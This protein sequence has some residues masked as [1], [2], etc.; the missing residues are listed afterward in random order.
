MPQIEE[1]RLRQLE[2]DAGRVQTLE[3]E[4]AAADERAAAA[5]RVHRCWRPATPRAR[6]PPPCS[7]SPA[8]F[9]PRPVRVVEESCSPRCR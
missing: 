3:A 8:P 4:R 2:T 1:A 6:S 9:R 7:P 5:E